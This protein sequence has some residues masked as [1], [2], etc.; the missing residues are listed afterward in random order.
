MNACVVVAIEDQS[1]SPQSDQPELNRMKDGFHFFE[2]NILVTVTCSYTSIEGVF[3]SNGV[4]LIGEREDVVSNTQFS[5]GV[6][7]NVPRETTVYMT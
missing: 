2:L 7:P 4:Q 5:G 3:Q 6:G 1:R